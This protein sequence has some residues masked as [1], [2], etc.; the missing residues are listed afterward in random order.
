M[1]F[2]HKEEREMTQ[3]AH[4]LTL[5]NGTDMRYLLYL[6]DDYQNDTIKLWP[7]I[8]FLHGSGERGTDA[9][10]VK[11]VG[12]PKRIDSRP[13]FPCIVLSPQCPL[14]ERWPEQSD[15]V[16]A[17]LDA[18]LPELHVDHSRIYLN[19]LSMGGQGAWHL[20]AL[21]PERFAAVLPICGRI[22]AVEGFPE[23]VCALEDVPVWVFHGAKD[24]RV[25][26]EDSITLTNILKD[27]GGNVQLTIF[28]DGDHF[29]WG[30]VYEDQ[31]VWD[32]LLA[33]RKI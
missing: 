5:N 3:T 20:G 18:V 25:P 32:W 30:R 22:P 27:C 16:I 12:L 15:D 33:Q 7:F 17:L 28:P 21:Y 23:Q 29:C 2:Y 6:T 4:Q 11:T 14:D 13:D 24:D 1:H 9:E 26:V 19:G 31:S 10:V 8:L